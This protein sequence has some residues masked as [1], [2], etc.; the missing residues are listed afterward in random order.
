M[1]AAVAYSI[2]ILSKAVSNKIPG[3]DSTQLKAYTE[4]VVNAQSLKEVDSLISEFN[5]DVVAKYFDL[6]TSGLLTLR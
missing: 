3:F 1:K 4:G 6:S 2:E 5:S